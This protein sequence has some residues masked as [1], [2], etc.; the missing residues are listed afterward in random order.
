MNSLTDIIQTNRIWFCLD[1]GKCSSVCPI[2]RHTVNGY[3]SPR[4]LVE[5]AI[6]MGEDPVQE[7]PL[8]WSC[9]TCNACSEICPSDVHFSDFIQNIRVRARAKDLSGDCT[10]S[11][12][13]QTWGRMMTD[14]DLEQIVW[15]GLERG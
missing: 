1:C 7:D 2:T 15:I 11:G 10:H 5:T 4:L 9:L 3:T 13:I 14:P 6:S 8:F 12:M